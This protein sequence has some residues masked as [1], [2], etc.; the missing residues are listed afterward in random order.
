MSTT[1]AKSLDD[2]VN[3]VRMVINDNDPDGYRFT[4]LQ[5]IQKI[6]TALREVYRYRPDAYVGNF[7]QGILST[8]SPITFAVSD[9]G[10]NPATPFPL[11]DRLFFAP[12]VFYVVGLLD[13]TDDEFADDNRA[14]TVLT[15]FRNELIGPGG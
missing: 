14:M 12:V 15:A 7:Q 3:E 9:L 5:V 10:L 8:N 1:T 2:A 6:N 13:L 11:D 4:Q